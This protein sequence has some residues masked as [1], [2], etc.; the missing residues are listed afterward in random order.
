MQQ[1]YFKDFE[2]RWSDIDANRHVGNYAYINMMSHTR[3]S[4]FENAGYGPL[5][6]HHAGFGPVLFRESIHFPIVDPVEGMFG[7]A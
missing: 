6:M 4:L 7:N 2:V 1:S 3:I 5:D